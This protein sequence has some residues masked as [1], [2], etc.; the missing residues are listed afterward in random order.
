MYGAAIPED[1]EAMLSKRPNPADRGTDGRHALPAAAGPRAG[2][3]AARG[4]RPLE[5]GLVVVVFL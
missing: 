4:A 2:A 1:A 3:G 5:L